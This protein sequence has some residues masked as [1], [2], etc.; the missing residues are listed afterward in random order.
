MSSHFEVRLHEKIA[1]SLCPTFI[2]K[3]LASNKREVNIEFVTLGEKI[4][5]D[6]KGSK[7]CHLL[8]S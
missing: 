6:K 8:L 4:D 3:E 1:F 2:S 7:L 5:M